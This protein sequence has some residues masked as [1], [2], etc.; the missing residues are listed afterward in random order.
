[1]AAGPE[2]TKETDQ[3]TASRAA[4]S[5]LR[6]V[7]R[8]LYDEVVQYFKKL[9]AEGGNGDR[10]TALI[11]TALLEYVQSIKTG[12]AGAP[13]TALAREIRLQLERLFSTNS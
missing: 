12:G 10:Y 8:Q 13:S 4:P 3:S 9:A 2:H 5:R 7:A 1:M 11:N 6:R